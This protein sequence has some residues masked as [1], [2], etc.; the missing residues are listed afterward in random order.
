MCMEDVDGAWDELHHRLM[1]ET[2]THVQNIFRRFSL[3]KVVEGH[4][5]HAVNFVFEELYLARHAFSPDRFELEVKI[6]RRKKII[7]YMNREI[8]YRRKFVTGF[9]GSAEDMNKMDAGAPNP[10]GKYNEFI[11]L[12]RTLDGLPQRYALVCRLRLIED[13]SFAD[14]AG[15]LKINESTLRTRFLRGMEK[16]KKKISKKDFPAMDEQKMGHS[17]SH[18]NVS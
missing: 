2:K 5:D 16:L 1:P 8:A 7:L 18:R 3:G 4:L 11:D 10:E 6:F 9:E 15:M 12:V 17:T 14:I 13:L